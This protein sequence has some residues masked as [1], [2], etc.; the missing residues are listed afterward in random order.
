MSIPPR[1]EAP[2]KAGIG[3]ITLG[4]YKGA[5]IGFPIRQETTAPRRQAIMLHLEGLIKCLAAQLFYSKDRYY[6]GICKDSIDIDPWH[7]MNWEINL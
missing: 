2:V 5:L 6:E 1:P 4:C 3:A 7:Y